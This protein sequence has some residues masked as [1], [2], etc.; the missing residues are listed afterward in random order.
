MVMVNVMRR[1]GSDGW[2]DGGTKVN[3]LAAGTRGPKQTA[4][5]H[6][7]AVSNA[8]HAAVESTTA[9]AVHEGAARSVRCRCRV[10]RGGSYDARGDAAAVASG[11][12]RFDQIR[13]L[14][15]GTICIVGWIPVVCVCEV[16]LGCVSGLWGICWGGWGRA[17][18]CRFEL[19]AMVE[20]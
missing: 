1:K 13:G 20:R 10:P 18:V 16:E 11:V 12:E 7:D 4:L 6:L 8:L 15:S 19:S 9:A 5:T 14:D 2:D 3:R 17:V